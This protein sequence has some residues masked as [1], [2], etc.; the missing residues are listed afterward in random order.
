LLNLD[1]AIASV[2]CMGLN[3]WFSFTP[4][5]L[6]MTTL[7]SCNDTSPVLVFIKGRQQ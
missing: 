2:Y 3:V 4:Y 1:T 6:F 7:I 5:T